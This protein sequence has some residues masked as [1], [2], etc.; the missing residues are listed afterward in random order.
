MAYSDLREFVR[1]LENNQELK[2]I[3]FEVDPHLEM[4]EFADQ[5]V[6]KGGCAT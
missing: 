3:S 2:R 4:T 1:E 6:K 5:A